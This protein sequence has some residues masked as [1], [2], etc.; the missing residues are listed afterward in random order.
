SSHRHW[1]IEAESVWRDEAEAI[2]H[3]AVRDLVL[4]LASCMHNRAICVRG[5]FNNSLRS[6][7]ARR[8]QSQ[9]PVP[10]TVSPMRRVHRPAPPAPFES[11]ETP[12]SRDRVC[13]Q[14]SG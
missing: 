4:P 14:W 2:S 9:T 13:R 10:R 11:A 7:T 8:Q 1:H 6:T 5:D 3:T 12:A